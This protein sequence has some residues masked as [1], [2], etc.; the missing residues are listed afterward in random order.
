LVVEVQVHLLHQL[1]EQFQVLIHLFL[2]IQLHT[3]LQVVVTEA[4]VPV[5][6]VLLVVQV[7]V[8][9]KMVILQEGLVTHLPLILLKVMLVELLDLVVVEM[10]VLAVVVELV[11]L[12]KQ[13][14]L[15]ELDEVVMVVMV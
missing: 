1:M 9:A 14:Q 8:E 13:E 3:L 6:L 5:R 15:M 4:V 12:E 2:Q 7:A 10:L 11:V